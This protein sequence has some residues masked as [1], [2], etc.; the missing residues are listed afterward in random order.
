MKYN[1]IVNKNHLPRTACKPFDWVVLYSSPASEDTTNLEL[2]K[3][4]LKQTER[5]RPGHS[6]RFV[7]LVFTFQP[8]DQSTVPGWRQK[9]HHWKRCNTIT[10]FVPPLDPEARFGG[11]PWNFR[12]GN[13]EERFGYPQNCCFDVGFC[14]NIGNSAGGAP[15]CDF[16]TCGRHA[17]CK[18]GVLSGMSPKKTVCFRKGGFVAL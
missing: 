8:T 13:L 15:S 2:L 1:I 9:Q 16:L 18:P 6:R 14:S 4:T 3:E 7:R 11:I 12:W 10:R 5:E 17:V